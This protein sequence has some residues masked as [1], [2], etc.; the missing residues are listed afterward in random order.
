MGVDT[1]SWLVVR[2]EVHGA[3]CVGDSRFVAENNCQA[4][5]SRGQETSRLFPCERMVSRGGD[6]GGAST[7]KLWRPLELIAMTLV[8]QGGMTP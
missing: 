3:H 5:A 7:A 4:A 6:A 8:S 1:L 2:G